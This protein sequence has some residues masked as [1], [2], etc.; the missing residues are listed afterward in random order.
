MI[1][2]RTDDA[3]RECISPL[4]GEKKKLI[5]T[6]NFKITTTVYSGR[7]NLLKECEVIMSLPYIVKYALL[8][9]AVPYL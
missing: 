3:E 9:I 4:Y 1:K 8:R 6:M 2:S 7:A 5:L